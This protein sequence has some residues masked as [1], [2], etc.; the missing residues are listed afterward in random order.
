MWLNTEDGKGPIAQ[1]ARK[2]TR[3]CVSV[4]S[5]GPD[6]TKK[7]SRS[8]FVP[9]I[10]SKEDEKVEDVLEDLQREAVER[11]IFMELVSNAAI[12]TSAPAWVREQSVLVDISSSVTLKFDMVGPFVLETGMELN[13]GL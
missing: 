2:P 8:T 4:V 1:G 6:G 7:T 10:V 5:T 12:L 3:L 9:K 13:V 11:E